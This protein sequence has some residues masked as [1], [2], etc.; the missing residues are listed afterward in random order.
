[1]IR[2]LLDLLQRPLTRH[3]VRE[4]SRIEQRRQSLCRGDFIGTELSFEADEFGLHV[5]PSAT[6]ESRF[7]A[8]QGAA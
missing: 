1:M 6:V 5:K 3:G 4:A 8:A 2:R 7:R